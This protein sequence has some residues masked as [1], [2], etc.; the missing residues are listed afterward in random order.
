MTGAL[1]AVPAAKVSPTKPRFLVAVLPEQVMAATGV[2]STGCAPRARAACAI[3]VISCRY[4]AVPTCRGQ[5]EEE[6]LMPNWM[7]R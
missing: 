6:S 1:V 7:N 5:V 2:S 4:R 3:M